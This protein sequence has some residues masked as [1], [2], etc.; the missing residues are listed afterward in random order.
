MKFLKSAVFMAGLVTAGM[1]LGA[2]APKANLQ[3]TMLTKV[4]P[5]GLALWD[6]TNNA[7]DA[8]GNFDGSKVTAANWAKL[9]EIGHALEEAGGSLA[10]SSG[11]IA[12]PPAAKLQDEGNPGAS[13]AADVQRYIDAKP[14][15]F[16]SHALELQKT[17]AAVVAAATKHDAK[18]LNALSNS[19]DG[20]CENCHMTFW[21]PQQKK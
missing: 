12:A 5:Q 17:G 1:V 9:A 15:V 4:N 16:R 8:E 3:L 18:R 6:I 21:Y 10:T 14:A 19:L 2:D 11:I 13:K 20:V 7:Q